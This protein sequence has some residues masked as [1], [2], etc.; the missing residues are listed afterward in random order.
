MS[1]IKNIPIKV[2]VGN[3]INYIVNEDKTDGY[4]YISDSGIDW[5]VANEEWK[6]IRKRYNKNSG[7]LAHHFIQSF[8]PK[9]G[10]TP[11]EAKRI[12]LEL[13]QRQF[14]RL[15]FDFIVATHVDTGVIHNHILVNNVSRTTGRKYNHDKKTYRFLR[16]L[17]IDVCRNNGVPAVDAHTLDEL[18]SGMD[19][20]KLGKRYRS[21]PYI[22]THTYDSWT[23]KEI[24]NKAKIR[25]D[26]NAAIKISGDWEDFVS[27]MERTGYRVDWQTKSGEDKKFVTYTP[28][29]AERGRRDRS[30]GMDWFS[31]DAI[32]ERIE[33]EKSRREREENY[34]RE[35]AYKKTYRIKKTMIKETRP[36]YYLDPNWDIR[37]LYFGKS[38]YRRRSWLESLIIKTFFQK[39]EVVKRYEKPVKYSP[40]VNKEMNEKAKAELEKSMRIFKFIQENGIKRSADADVIKQQNELQIFIKN[41]EQEE[42]KKRL[43]SLDNAAELFRD[44]ESNADTFD[45]WQNLSG[46]EKESFYYANKQSIQ[47]YTL[48][49]RKLEKL[50]LIEKNLNEIEIEQMQLNEMITNLK[51]EIVSIR[52]KNDTISETVA[53][54]SELE[55]RQKQVKL[56]EKHLQNVKKEK[57][58]CEQTL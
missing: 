48:A 7:I 16:Q 4:I 55:R 14:G 35:A 53:Y 5:H 20:I 52:V 51:N 57:R 17:N 56:R 41:D 44:M 22:K 38:K 12:G 15:G 3:C 39:R 54:I 37:P 23:Q 31:K 13:A 34:E 8:D 1:Y 6:Q 21:K 40:A 33:K 36:Q 24:T 10:V 49:K 32:I 11:E 42:L 2:S 28:E 29:K 58:R 46:S 26:I 45:E 25:T 43:L 30:L 50:E 47:K 27:N 19:D 18:Y 9:H